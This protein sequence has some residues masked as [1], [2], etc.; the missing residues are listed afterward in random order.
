VG[1]RP[2]SFL[3]TG[4]RASR[5]IPGVRRA[6]PPVCR[7][8]PGFA[9]P[10]FFTAGLTR[11]SLGRSSLADGV[12]PVAAVSVLFFLGYLFTERMVAIVKKG[13]EEDK[14]QS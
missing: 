13:F 14:K 6:Y 2:G 10:I 12:M 9:A 5:R 8:T 11:L 3:P 7:L 4:W 1:P